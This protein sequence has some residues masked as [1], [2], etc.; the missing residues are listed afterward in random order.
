MARYVKHTHRL[1]SH[2]TR[3]DVLKVPRTA[4]LKAD[5][6]VKMASKKAANQN[7]VIHFARVERSSLQMEDFVMCIN[8]KVSS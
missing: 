4:N 6:L 8:P 2:L 1:L 5:M 7:T 3:Y